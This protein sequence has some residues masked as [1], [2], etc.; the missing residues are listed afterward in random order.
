MYFAVLPESR[1]TAKYMYV[2]QSVCGVQ[3]INVW[4]LCQSKSFHRD[5]HFAVLP[6][7]RMTAK[8]MYSKLCV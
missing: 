8:Y 2:F 7:G 1:M 3:E 4:A 6:E 5:M